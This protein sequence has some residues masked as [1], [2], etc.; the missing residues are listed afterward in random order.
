MAEASEDEARVDAEL[1][2]TERSIGELQKRRAELLRAKG[3]IRWAKTTASA[4][5]PANPQHTVPATPVAAVASPASAKALLE[6]LNSLDWSSF[7][8]K[9]G[10]WTF[11]RN[12]DGS[13]VDT[14]ATETDFVNQLRRGKELVVGRY[15]Y[16]VSE[17]KF[18]NRHFEA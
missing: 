11:L 2:E 8:K 17:D 9:E 18:L 16:A 12:R 6:A 3:T 5:K 13:L 7:K 15:R 14:L 4:S 1:K 10:E